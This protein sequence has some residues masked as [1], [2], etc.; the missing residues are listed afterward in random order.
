MKFFLYTKSGDSMKSEII[1]KK[2]R[3]MIYISLFLA[4]IVSLVNVLPLKKVVEENTWIEDYVQIC[5]H[6]GGALLNP[7]NTKKAFDYV[8]KETTYTDII[9]LDL[10]LTKDN[11]IV[12]NHDDDINRMALD[13]SEESVK[14]SE[15]N[16]IDLLNYNLGRNFTSL[17]GKTPYKNYSVSE[18]YNA[19]L[20]LMTIEDFFVRYNEYREFKLFIEIKEDGEKGK[21]I[22]DEVMKL[23][24]EYDFYKSRSMFI[25]FD[26]NLLGYIK[27]KYPG[28]YT[29]AL[30][31]DVIEQIVFSKVSLDHFYNPSYECIQVP[32]NDK[33]KSIP[34]VRLDDKEL[35]NTFKKRNQLV[36]YWGIVTKEDMKKLISNGVHVITTDRPDLLA[37]VL[38]R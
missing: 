5:A 18:A 32:Y 2:S 13:S 3:V 27:N 16:Y 25:A 23:F 24:D 8:I 12:I 34:L 31:N 4:F 15:H 22:I 38:G 11:V 29:G 30:G 19:G 21:Y 35:I 28:Q 1:N 36:V 7:E 9:E 33:A 14:I 37:E 6:R 17:D 20:T 26:D 10:K